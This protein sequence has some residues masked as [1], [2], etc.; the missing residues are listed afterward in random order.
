MLNDKDLKAKKSELE[1]LFFQ[2][3][4]SIKTHKN[5]HC[6]KSHWLPEE[7]EEYLGEYLKEDSN[8]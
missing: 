8:D 7:L 3:K 2:T 4:K 1:R 6:Q 5:N